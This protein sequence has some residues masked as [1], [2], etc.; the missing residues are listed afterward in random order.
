MEIVFDENLLKQVQKYCKIHA[1]Q[2]Y[3]G[4]GS[5]KAL[6]LAEE[7]TQDVMIDL[8]SKRDGYYKKKK[9]T[10]NLLFITCRNK[11]GNLFGALNRMKR[12]HYLDK[13]SINLDV[14]QDGGYNIE[15]VDE[16]TEEH[17]INHK[18]EREEHI[19]R[20]LQ[21]IQDVLN[22]NKS[23]KVSDKEIFVLYYLEGYTQKSIAELKSKSYQWVR[24][25]IKRIRT[26]I[27]YELDLSDK[28]AKLLKYT[29]GTR[30]IVKE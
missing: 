23:I 5:R 8:W 22:D 28:E 19:E 11:V 30:K 27:V 16:D 18:Q 7:A 2:Y 24:N 21:R 29:I 13:N 25:S 1:S 12:E 20:L 6:Y 15:I 3:G 4:K 26:A 10:D 14:T 17:V 9:L